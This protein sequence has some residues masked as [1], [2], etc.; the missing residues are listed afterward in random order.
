MNSSVEPTFFQQ[1]ANFFYLQRNLNA[2]L[3]NL[4]PTLVF[5]IKPLRLSS[6]I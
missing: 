1:S 5:K 6:S 3:L 4:G 2:H